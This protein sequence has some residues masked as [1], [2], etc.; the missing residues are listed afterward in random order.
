MSV[1]LSAPPAAGAGSPTAGSAFDRTIL[2]ASLTPLFIALGFA[3]VV[4]ANPAVRG[5]E[6]LSLVPG[7]LYRNVIITIPAAGVALFVFLL[8][9]LARGETEKRPVALIRTM[10]RDRW[11][12][13]R[14]VSVVIPPIFCALLLGTFTTFKQRILPSAGFGMD[15]SLAAVDRFL[16]LG[17]DPWRLTHAIASGP[18]ATK[19]IDLAYAAW[20]VP[21]LLMPLLSWLLPAPLRVRILIGFALVWIVL[22]AVSAFLLPSAGPCFYAAFHAPYSGFTELNA[23]LAE[24]SAALAADG[25]AGLLA[26]QGQAEL[27]DAFQSQ[28]FI[29][30][31]GI[32]AMPSLH[33]ALATLM[34]LVGFRV[35]AL[36]GRFFTGFALLISFGSVHLGWHYAMDGIV[37]VVSTIGLWWVAGRWTEKLLSNR[38]AEHP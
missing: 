21:M 7:H 33:V 3:L 2:R 15:Q 29:M 16:F 24:Q 36:V 8:V 14:L 13:D 23:R 19:V 12:S 28:T 22:G 31:G 20:I 1:E 9:R 26:L 30:V 27:L 6:A 4:Q 25:G 5:G 37:S 34:A 32:S 18:T 11:R 10:V 35:H 17:V 38:A